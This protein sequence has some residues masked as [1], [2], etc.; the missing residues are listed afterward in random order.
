ML[1][2]REPRLPRQE[3]RTG[4][5]LGADCQD[6]GLLRRALQGPPVRVPAPVQL[7]RDGK[8]PLQNI[9]PGRVPRADGR[10][11]G[12]HRARA[13]QGARQVVRRYQERSHPHSRGR[14][15]HYR[16]AGTARQLC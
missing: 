6:V 16:Q 2:R 13:T 10:R 7:V 14:H 3:G 8:R 4:P 11:G 15:P 12:A 1:A 5:A 9:V